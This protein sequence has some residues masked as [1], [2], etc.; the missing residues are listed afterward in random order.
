M[1][2]LHS[3]SGNWEEYKSLLRKYRLSSIL[4][5]I[6]K[7][8]IELANEGTVGATK[9]TQVLFIQTGSRLVK[10]QDCLIMGWTLSDLAYHAI[11][12]T[13]DYRGK[14]I[15][16]QNEFYSLVLAE[17]AYHQ[18]TE[19]QAIEKVSGTIDFYAYL[20]GFCGEQ[21]KYEATER[22]FENLVRDSYILFDIA[23]RIGIDYINR[24]IYDE[25]GV[26]WDILY[27]SL[28]LTWTGSTLK[29]TVEDITNSV[30]WDDSFTKSAYYS[31]IDRYTSTI[32]DVRK[33]NLGRQALYSTPYVRVGSYTMCIN[34]YLGI[35]AYEHCAFWIIRNYFNA[36]NSQQFTN[37][38]GV[39]FE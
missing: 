4:K 5:W 23:D 31:V 36:L 38:F 7:E 14:E 12:S 1:P 21:F 25:L 9:R 13:N 22:V 37:D 18:T 16:T 6:N 3:Y 27:A 11:L 19:Q 17:N 32:D 10:K 24:I 26:S 35:F 28:L 2:I 33:S 39:M 20:W 34:R 15:E 30:K 29:N 8:S